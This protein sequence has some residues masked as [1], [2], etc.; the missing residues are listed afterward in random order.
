MADVPL[1][2][3]IA[4]VDRELA[5]RAKAFPRWIDQKKLTQKAADAEITKPAAAALAELERRFPVSA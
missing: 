2:D 1:E 4:C 5:F 3:L